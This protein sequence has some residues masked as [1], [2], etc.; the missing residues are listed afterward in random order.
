MSKDIQKTAL[1]LPRDL[2]TA[3]HD[4]ASS[5]GR[6]MNAEIIYRLQ[7]TFDEDVELAGSGVKV[8]DGLSIDR[9]EL[10]LPLG[11]VLTA[12]KIDKDDSRYTPYVR[13][14]EL[15]EVLD[16]IRREMKNKKD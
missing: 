1:R 11:T 4:A 10:A 14:E 8:I 12:R 13:S 2:H 9:S 7:R 5:S 3:I 16:Y 6:T 15:Q